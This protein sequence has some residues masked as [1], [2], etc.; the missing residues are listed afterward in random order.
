M[1]TPIE[2]CKLAKEKG[3]NY[4]TQYAWCEFNNNKSEVE[5]YESILKTSPNEFGNYFEGKNWNEESFIGDN[6]IICSAPD[7]Y[8]LREWIAEKYDFDVYIGALG[9]D[10]NGNILWGYDVISIEEEGITYLFKDT[11]IGYFTYENAMVEAINRVLI[12][13]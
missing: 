10:G 2:V 4:P 5:T 9:K 6:K 8:D 7:I 13:V 1:I 11:P 12:T 3:F